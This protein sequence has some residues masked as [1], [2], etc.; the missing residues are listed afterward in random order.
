[1]PIVSKIIKKLIP[2]RKM[3]YL[4]GNNILFRYRFG[5]CKSHS[6]DAYILYLR[7]N[8]LTGFDS[9]LLTRIIL[10]D[11]KKAFDNTNYKLLLRK[12]ASLGFSNQSMLWFQSYLSIRRFCV[13]FKTNT[14]LLRNL[15]ICQTYIRYF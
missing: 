3:D 6:T 1:M 5:F 15:K 8:I 12:M 11:Y 13:N 4:R 7:D 14:G 9:N 2:D 10:I